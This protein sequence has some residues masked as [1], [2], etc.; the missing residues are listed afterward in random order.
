MIGGLR[1]R[2]LTHRL[3]L[4][5]ADAMLRRDAASEIL[6]QLDRHLTDRAFLIGDIYTI[7]DIALYGYL[8]VAAEARLGLD[9]FR[10]CAAAW[11]TLPTLPV[12][13]R[14]ARRTVA[15]QSPGRVARSTTEPRAGRQ[16]LRSYLGARRGWL[17]GP[18]CHSRSGC[19][20]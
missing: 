4:S 11:P 2:L 12:S 19:V 17:F 8:H 1:F 13:S 15:T 5:D 14:I 16:S 6:G 18:G 10:I 20:V 9:H 7:A 3:S